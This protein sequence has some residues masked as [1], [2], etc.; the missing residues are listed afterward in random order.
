MSCGI[1]YLY[2]T[3]SYA[4]LC[5]LLKSAPNPLLSGE[6]QAVFRLPF[7]WR[8]KG[9]QQSTVTLLRATVSEMMVLG[10]VPRPLDSKDQG[11]LQ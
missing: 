5:L 1:S 6:A 3:C 8:G 10:L 4:S 11:N 9:A 7:C 2:K